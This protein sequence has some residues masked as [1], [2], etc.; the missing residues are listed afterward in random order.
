[1]SVLD[2]HEDCSIAWFKKEALKCIDE[3][4]ARGNIPMLVGGSMLYVSALI[5]GLEPIA[6]AD[7]ALRARLEAEYDADAGLTLSKRLQEIDPETA[8]SFPMQNK[9]YVVRALEIYESTGQ[10]KSSLKRKSQSPYDLLM[11][12]IDTEREELKK[13]IEER[14][15]KMLTNGW[16]QEV[17]KLKEQGITASAPA[18]QSIGYREIYDALDA[19]NQMELTQ[20]IASKTSAYA[21]RAMTW[22]RRDA[23]IK[24]I[25]GSDTLRIN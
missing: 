10:T 23:R 14:T 18:M 2:A 3:I 22:W 6:A 16:I 12:G 8:A 19:M 5:D 1:L 21:K 9:V 11:F 25:L 13:R 20:T 4:H 7:P 15:M 24:W 17:Q